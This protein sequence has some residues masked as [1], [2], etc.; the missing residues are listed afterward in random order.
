MDNMK[1]VYDIALK[2]KASDQQLVGWL[3]FFD[4]HDI[5]CCVSGLFGKKPESLSH[6]TA[7]LQ[8]LLPCPIENNLTVYH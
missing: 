4:R 3:V 8:L 6:F 5:Y 1:N 2:L 7:V